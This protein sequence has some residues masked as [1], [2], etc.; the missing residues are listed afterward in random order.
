MV[1]GISKIFRR[2]GV[3]RISFG[4]GEGLMRKGRPIF[5]DGVQVLREMCLNTELFLVR[6]FLSS[7]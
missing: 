4:E 2:G 1:K 6:I 3:S 5:G 7:N